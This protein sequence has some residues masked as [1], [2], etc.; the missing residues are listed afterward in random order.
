MGDERGAVYGGELLS[1]R[2][3]PN[4]TGLG[5]IQMGLLRVCF[6]YVS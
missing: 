4:F 3:E 6:Y 1:R 2:A 5:V